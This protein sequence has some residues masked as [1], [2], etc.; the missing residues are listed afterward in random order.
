M[1]PGHARKMIATMREVG[2]ESA[3]VWYY[4]NIAGGH[5]AAADTK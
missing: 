2:S 4:E 3:E 5:G 1:R